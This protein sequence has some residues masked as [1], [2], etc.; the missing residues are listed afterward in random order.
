MLAANLKMQ[1]SNSLERQTGNSEAPEHQTKI[2]AWPATQ[3]LTESGN[4]YTFAQ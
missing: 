2:D 1:S 4:R 3:S